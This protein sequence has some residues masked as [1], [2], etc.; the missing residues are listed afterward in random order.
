[1]KKKLIAGG[2]LL[3]LAAI[4]SFI[5][6]LVDVGIDRIWYLVPIVM[7][8]V[9]GVLLIDVSVN[10]WSRFSAKKKQGRGKT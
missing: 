6:D 8:V 2:V 7:L 5:F 9:S 3:S 4:L 10:T 1:M